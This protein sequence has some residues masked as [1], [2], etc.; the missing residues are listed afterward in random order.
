MDF[1]DKVVY[2]GSLDGIEPTGY[3]S[4]TLTK[5]KCYDV[6]RI[7]KINDSVYVKVLNDKGIKFNYRMSYFKTLEE[8]REEK[9]TEILKSE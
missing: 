9:L 2:I 3:K 7:S 8:I 5:G 4:V 1:V 6:I